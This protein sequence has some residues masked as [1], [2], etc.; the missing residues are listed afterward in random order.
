ML[1][2]WRTK[3]KSNPFWTD[4]QKWMNYRYSTGNIKPRHR[5]WYDSNLPNRTNQCQ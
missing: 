5:F 3:T 4:M 1:R 2:E